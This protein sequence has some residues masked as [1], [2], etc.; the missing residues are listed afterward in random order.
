MPQR[1]TQPAE[2]CGRSQGVGLHSLLGQFRARLLQ[3]LCVSL[4]APEA[5]RN[6]SCQL[7]GEH[8]PDALGHDCWQGHVPLS[9]V[10]S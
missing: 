5:C 2:R 7:A 8:S 6:R 1:L 4:A 3:V 10:L 9:D